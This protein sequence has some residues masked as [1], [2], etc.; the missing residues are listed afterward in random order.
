MIIETLVVGAMMVN[1]Y[2]VGSG[3]GK[4]AA[5]IDPGDN[6][7]G[8]L[9]VLKDKSLDLK[10]IIF[11][12]AHF[13]HLGA[14]RELQEETGATILLSEKDETLLKNID[15]Q[16]SLF[17]M[18]TV[19]RPA[20]HGFVKEGDVLKVDGLRLRIIETPGHSPGGISIY[21]EEEGVV[22]TGDTLFWGAVG[23]TDLPGSDHD[24][25]IE[26]LKEKLGALPDETKVY[27][28]HFDDTSIGFEKEQNPFFE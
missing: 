1:C 18:P 23:R 13:D 17:D 11:T 26:S 21:I 7:P 10:Y 25:L 15:T 22:F 9:G 24:A 6:A 2:I 28:G 5:V 12:H 4:E 27:P 14:A 8:I 20:E 16:A 19:P 3:T